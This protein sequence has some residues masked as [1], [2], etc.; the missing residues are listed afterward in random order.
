MKTLNALICYIRSIECLH[1]T[2]YLRT[3]SHPQT[4]NRI[5]TVVAWI[6]AILFVVTVRFLVCPPPTEKT[7]KATA[8]VFL[9]LWTVVPPV[10]FWIEYRLL[11]GHAEPNNRRNLE[12]FKHGQEVS[13]N[14]W[15]AFVAILAAL[16]FG[17]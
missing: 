7:A 13:R 9:V 8:Q 11:W 16:Y 17:K 15:L 6:A 2:H 14:I 3:G 5:V 4:L 10:W 1:A 12:E